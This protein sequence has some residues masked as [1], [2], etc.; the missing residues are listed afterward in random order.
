MLALKYVE[1]FAI[2]F[3]RPVVICLG[4]GTNT[5]DHSGSS[6]LAGYMNSLA[7][8]RSRAIVVCGGNEGNAAHHFNGRLFNNPDGGINYKDVEIRVGENCEG[9]FLEFWGGI[10]DIFNIIIRSPG[11]ESTPPLRLGSEQSITYSFI[12]EKT[13]I[14][15]KSVFIEP[16]TGEELII[17][18][19]SKPTNGIWNIR[20]STVGEVHNGSYNL[21]L[22][23]TEFSNSTVYFLEPDPYITLT[24]PAMA[25]EVISV[26][27]YNDVNK[28]FFIESGRGL[29][30]EERRVG[31]EG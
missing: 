27:T 20:V 4:V 18:R 29:R 23:I 8:K 25:Q 10:P 24:E 5:G 2:T 15:I 17:M 9:F 7:L 13:R 21:W 1:S 14:T 28:S 31:K 11:G 26:S 12:Y 30:S 6:F 16:N 19:I 3:R 22:P